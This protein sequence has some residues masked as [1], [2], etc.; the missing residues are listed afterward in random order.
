MTASLTLGGF[1][2]AEVVYIYVN[3]PYMV[4]KSTG[5]KPLKQRNAE[6]SYLSAF[7]VFNPSF[8]D[9]KR[10]P[11]CQFS[12]IKFGMKWGMCVLCMNRLQHLILKVIA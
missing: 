5:K 6:D 3:Y 12:S 8:C 10:Y 9:F 2:V 7:L 1:Q 4:T 11:E